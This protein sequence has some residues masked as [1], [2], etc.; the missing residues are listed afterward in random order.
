MIAASEKYVRVLVRVPEAYLLVRALDAIRPGLLVLDADGRRVDSIA[1]PGMGAPPIDAATIAKRLTAAQ[2]ATAVELW[3][4]RLSGKVDAVMAVRKEIA[5]NSGVQITYKKD[6]PLKLRVTKNAL[7]PERL[8]SIAQE[9]AVTVTWQEPVPIHVD[10]KT[11]TTVAGA[12]HIDAPTERAFVTALL[13]DP[14]RLPKGW[15]ADLESKTYRLP[16]IP[17]GG[18]GCQ[19]ALAPTNTPGVVAIFAD[20]FNEQQVVVARK[21]TVD[22]KAVRQAFVDAGCKAE[23]KK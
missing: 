6:A 21:K 20:I 7:T 19:V 4:L 15:G 5:K 9:R 22:W 16:N 18:S 14:T 8:T 17:K 3:R 13:L 23:E 12:W 1:F 10:A 11:K 2:S